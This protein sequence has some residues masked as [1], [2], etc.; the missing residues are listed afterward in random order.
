MNQNFA[1][2]LATLPTVNHLAG[3]QLIWPD[4]ARVVI[5]NKPGSQGSLRIYH[6]LQARFG[7][8]DAVAAAEGLRLYAEHGEDARRNP[9]KHPN[10]DRLLAIVAGADPV[11]A[12]LLLTA[13]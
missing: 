1:E 2:I 4:D 5:E 11:R 9:G 13:P 6:H 12:R 7:A 3:I 8:I 10:I